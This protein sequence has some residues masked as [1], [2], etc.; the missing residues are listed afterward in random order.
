MA[1]RNWLLALPPL[2]FLAFAGVAWVGLHRENPEELP[3]ALVGRSAPGISRLTAL[4]DD[5]APTDADL[6]APPRMRSPGDGAG[7][8]AD[9]AA[10]ATVWAGWNAYEKR[11]ESGHTNW[12]R[13]RGARSRAHGDRV[14]PRL[15]L[16]RSRA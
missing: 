14:S 15:R 13:A 1:G 11:M 12:R 2:V 8:E 16:A 10:R 4:R 3:S 7:L 9:S 5:P 6:R